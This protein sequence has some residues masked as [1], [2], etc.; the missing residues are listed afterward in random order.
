MQLEFTVEYP[1]IWSSNYW[2]K[3]FNVYLRVGKKGSNWGYRTIKKLTISE[4]EL[5]YVREKL[6]RDYI[7][8][9]LP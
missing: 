1:F 7:N 8:E 4:N 6:V 9:N 2:N 3:K 5:D